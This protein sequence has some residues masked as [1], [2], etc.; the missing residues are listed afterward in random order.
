MKRTQLH[1]TADQHNAK[2]QHA[3][4]RWIARLKITLVALAAL[5][6]TQI[7]FFDSR[8]IPAATAQQPAGQ[9]IERFDFL[10]REDFFAGLAGDREKFQR[11]MKLCEDTLAKNPK[12]ADAM[13]WHGS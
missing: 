12:H 5:A 3:S 8:L 11:A 7:F 4:R 9:R 6:V 1:S 13:V 10:V 2:D